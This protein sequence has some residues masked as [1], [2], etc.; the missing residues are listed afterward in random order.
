[1]DIWLYFYEQ[2]LAEYDPRL[3]EERGVYYTPVQVVQA[4]VRLVGKILEQDFNKP[5]TF[6]DE[7]VTVLDPAIGTGTYALAAF[8][9]GLERVRDRFGPGAVAGRAAVLGSNLHGFEI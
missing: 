2:F 8:D 7:G 5:L 4:Q 6:A 9:H 3:R 1:T